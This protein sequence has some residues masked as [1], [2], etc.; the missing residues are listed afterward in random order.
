MAGGCSAARARRPMSPR[1][2]PAHRAVLSMSPNR[3]PPAYARGMVQ[4]VSSL[5]PTRRRSHQPRN[6]PAYGRSAWSRRYHNQRNPRRPTGRRF[7]GA[8][9]SAR[10]FRSARTGC[11]R[12]RDRARWPRLRGK[13]RLR[14]RLL[15]PSLVRPVFPLRKSWAWRSCIRETSTRST[16]RLGR[17]HRW[18]PSRPFLRRRL[19]HR[20]RLCCL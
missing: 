17:R 19:H 14:R 8:P 3:M 1:R 5:V 6:R 9:A 20:C 18:A 12:P 13:I 4:R 16:G 11:R 2:A 7:R 15:R 10:S